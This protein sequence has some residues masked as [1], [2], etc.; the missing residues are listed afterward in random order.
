MKVFS[1]NEWSPL[2]TVIVGNTFKSMDIDIDMSFKL[3]FKDFYDWGWLNDSKKKIKI[4]K[5]YIEELNEDLCGFVVALKNENINVLRPTELKKITKIKTPFWETEMIPA[6]NVRDQTIIIGDTIVET[7]PMLRQRYFEND[8]LKDIFTDA[9]LDGSK[10]LQM[11]KATLTDSSIKAQNEMMI[12]GAQFVRFG[13]DII[14][15]ISNDSH[16]QALDWFR[17]Q[18]PDYTFHVI[19]SLVENHLDSYVVPLCE[20]VLLLRDEKF[21]EQMPA[22]LKDWNILYPPKVTEDCFPT[23][24]SGDNLLTSKFI[25]MNVLSLDGNKIIT[26]SMFPELSDM[27]Y[28][29]GFDPIP[30]QHRHR[31]IF[32]GGFHCFTLDLLREN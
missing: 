30:V 8:L 6:L 14:V 9:H 2:K 19:N 26:N 17:L 23:Y 25:D 1:D 4:K 5:Q 16:A 18:F 32:A 12:D 31:R 10:W 22:F 21:L 27:L 3:F 13:K 28:E 11:P 7:P 20:G 29:N 24:D 15:N